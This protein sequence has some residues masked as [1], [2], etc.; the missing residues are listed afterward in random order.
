MPTSSFFKSKI[1]ILPATIVAILL[2]LPSYS[3]ADSYSFENNP[4]QTINNSSVNIKHGWYWEDVNKTK[5]PKLKKMLKMVNPKNDKRKPKEILSSIDNQMKVQTLLLSKMLQILEYNF[6]RRTPKYTINKKTGKKCLTNS[7]ADCFVMPVVPEAQQVPVLK[8]FIRKPNLETAKEWLRWFATYQNKIADVGYANSFAYKQYGTKAYPTRVTLES[9]TPSGTGDNLPKNI[10]EQT[11]MRLQNRI[12]IYVFYGINKGYENLINPIFML[13]VKKGAFSVFK[14][15]TVVFKDESYYNK[16]KKEFSWRAS[17][18]EKAIANSTKFKLDPE[19]FKKFKIDHTPTVVAEL[20]GKNGKILGWQKIC[21]DNGY[22][23]M[24]SGV[25]DFLVFNRVVK[26]T[27]IN[28]ENAYN[29]T[30]RTTVGKYKP[31]NMR[32]VKV[33]ANDE[34]NYKLKFEKIEKNK[35]VG[36]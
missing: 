23:D 6:P 30:H 32:G 20:K 13:D 33:Q 21:F 7:N 25:Y 12:K 36:K 28:P 31:R 19:L 11:L 14:D 24:L 22:G 8:N 3:F 10:K 26:P 16:L 2:S 4:L 9:Q 5:K 18:R 1:I 34:K 29:A 15:F 17:S 27:N 35:K